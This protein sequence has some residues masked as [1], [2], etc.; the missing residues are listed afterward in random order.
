MPS[1]V[2]QLSPSRIKLTI[3]IP[4][5]DLQPHLNK[6]YR[7]IASQVNIPGFR[8]GKVP[9]QII[10][11]RFG[12]GMV[13]QEAINEALPSAYEAALAESGAV[14]LGQPEVDVTKLEDGELVEFTAEVDVRPDFDL[15]DFST[16][17][18]EVEPLQPT[19]T[20]VDERIEIMRQR[21][22]TREDV[23]RAAADG[24]VV[25]LD[26][27][28]TKDGE[29]IEDAEASG[30]TYKLGSG[31]MLE[32]LDE[33]V[34]GKSAGES[35]DFS[36][37]LVGGPAKDSEADIHVEITKVQS[38]TLPEVDDEFAQMISEFDTVEEMRSDL[39][40]RVDQM[41]Q[42]EQVNQA[43]DKVLEQLVE[44]ADF[45]LPEGLVAA[46]VENRTQQINSQ[47]E[48]AGY[49]LER[50]LDETEEEAD[51]PEEFWAE[52]EKRTREALKA[53][54]IL[55]KLA[56]DNEIGV[57]QQELTEMLFRRAAQNQTTPEA[58]AQHMMEH[59]HAPEWMQEIRRSKALQ[60]IVT[61][62]TVTDTEGNAVDVAIPGEETNEDD[63]ESPESP[64]SPES[65][66]S[67][68]SPES[69]ESADDDA[70][71]D[72][73]EPDAPKKAAKSA[74]AGKPAKAKKPAKAEKSAQAEEA[75]DGSADSA[76]DDGTAGTDDEASAE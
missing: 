75:A 10:D 65:A 1:T 58:E 53:Q 46:E 71:K 22:A 49:T 60:S 15:P 27:T 50:Y 45:E 30:V 33:A 4:F 19:E 47:L 12:R 3:E 16:L 7:E 5:E 67:P 42:V 37:T 38:E 35:A 11:Q 39:A 64:D 28:A 23:D 56:D 43:R 63:D 74:K 62:A 44:K 70:T 72:E 51:T 34:T 41:A 2:E 24:D 18:V 14:P 52:I 61:A 59:N 73:A 21:F 32:G 31:G 9:A 54:I 68:D 66:E 6:A 40:T 17:S 76:A 26:I 69:A 57:D 20:E 13:L 8:K 25:T 55:D 29:A 48:Q 36:S